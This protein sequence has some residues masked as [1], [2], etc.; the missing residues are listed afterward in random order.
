MTA[1]N[2]IV[3]QGNPVTVTALAGALQR[4]L[5]GGWYWRSGDAEPRVRDLTLRQLAPNFRCA[6]YGDKTCVEIPAGWRQARCRLLQRRRAALEPAIDVA[7][8]A[9]AAL[10]NGSSGSAAIT[11][12]L[13][14]PRPHSESRTASARSWLIRPTCG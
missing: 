14:C 11:A 10:A 9:H 13:T 5:L 7:A 8:H 4:R 2:V 3:P 6:T 1:G 12:P